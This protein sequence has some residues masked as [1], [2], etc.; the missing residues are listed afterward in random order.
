MH[1]Q[2]AGVREGH[3]P[4]VVK[5]IYDLR[6]TQNKHS[7]EEV[8]SL[9]RG[10][11]LCAKML[12]DSDCLKLRYERV[13]SE[14][15][16]LLHRKVIVNASTSCLVP[17][18]PSSL[19]R[20]VGLLLD[21]QK[22]TVRHIC[23]GDASVERVDPTGK[24]IAWSSRLHCFCA[25]QSPVAYKDCKIWDI[26]KEYRGGLEMNVMLMGSDLRTHPQFFV[27]TLNELGTSNSFTESNSS[28]LEYNEVILDYEKNS[29]VGYVVTSGFKF[30]SSKDAKTNPIAYLQRR[31]K[32]EL[33]LDLC[34]FL[35]NTKT[36]A[37]EEYR[38]TPS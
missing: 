26:K 6:S 5:N 18:K 35:Y 12:V 17:Q 30:D 9:Y 8:Q 27:G 14:V 31:V 36:G 10:Y 16:E 24:P 37:I 33:S 4:F 25:S 21:A 3:F 7:L 38:D 34:T 28:R 29:I 15:D 32:G 2:P 23:R 13:E 11:R 19:Y 1:G 22:C 20:T